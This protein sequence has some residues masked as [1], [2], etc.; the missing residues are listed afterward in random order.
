MSIQQPVPMTVVKK[1]GKFIVEPEVESKKPSASAPAPTPVAP[2]SN[3]T[4]TL[5][6]PPT[7]C[8]NGRKLMLP[9]AGHEYHLPPAYPPLMAFKKNHKERPEIYDT[10]VAECR[11]WRDNYGLKKIGIAFIWERLRYIY[12]IKKRLGEEFK[13]N[14]NYKGA[15][16]RVVMYNERDLHGF[17]TTRE[18]SD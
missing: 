10:I 17:I 5:V 18:L 4:P 8:A 6:A 7:T 11:N 14:N 9:P 13:L 15:Y 3:P 12:V 2:Q 1:N 16:A